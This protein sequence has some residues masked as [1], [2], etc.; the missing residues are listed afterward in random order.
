MT[1]IGLIS[2]THGCWDDRYEQ[3]LG[4]CDEIWHAG[5]IGSIELADRFEAMKPRFRAVWGNIDDAKM[6]VRYSEIQQ[7]RVE[8]INVIMKHIGGYP[9]HYDASVRELIRREPPQLFVS[10]HS[11]ILKVMPDKHLGL[12]HIN[13]GAAGKAGWHKERTLVRLTIDGTRF[14]DCEVITLGR[15]Q[16]KETEEL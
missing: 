7:F 14:A 3:Y 5:D 13:P 4:G 16:Q 6:H 10:G 15:R 12:L 9:G 11:H 2:D 8:G 1:V